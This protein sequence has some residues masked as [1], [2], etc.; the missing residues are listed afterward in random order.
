MSANCN[1]RQGESADNS[2]L[3]SIRRK[4]NTMQAVV[5]TKAA[6]FPPFEAIELQFKRSQKQ[7]CAVWVWD[8]TW[9]SA[10]VVNNASNGC[11]VV[12]LEHGVTFKVK[13]ANVLPR[14]PDSRGSDRPAS[15]E[16]RRA[17]YTLV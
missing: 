7:G 5:Q 17:Y 16:S 8:S 9:L 1:H 13:T 6:R 11:V 4:V 3:R 2:E 14:D 12:R 15:V 10:V